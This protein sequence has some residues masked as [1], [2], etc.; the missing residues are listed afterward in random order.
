[1]V[2]IDIYVHNIHIRL[3]SNLS[4]QRCVVSMPINQVVFN[5]GD[6]KPTLGIREISQAIP[7]YH[8]C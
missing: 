7:P 5:I 1:M 6:F 8:Y 2:Y 3:I 4:L